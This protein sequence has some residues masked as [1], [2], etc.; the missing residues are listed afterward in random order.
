M[1]LFQSMLKAVGYTLI[2][3]I[4]LT[5]AIALFTPELLTNDS[6]V[7][8]ILSILL[9]EISLLNVIVYLLLDNDSL[10]LVI[11]LANYLT[12]PTI[13]YLKD[14]YLEE[15]LL[16]GVLAIIFLSCWYTLMLARASK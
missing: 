10:R 8:M 3:G 4:M 5:F 9:V 16:Q 15:Q 11:I 13:M 6:K 1:N 7:V 12:L 14:L 2:V